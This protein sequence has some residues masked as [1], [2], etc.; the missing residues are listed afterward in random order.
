MRSNWLD[1]SEYFILNHWHRDERVDG[2]DDVFI[3]AE[4]D[5]HLEGKH[6]LDP[7]VS[8]AEENHVP[9]RETETECVPESMSVMFDESFAEKRHAESR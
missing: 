7:L 8:R 3:H 1:E 2:P 9:P 4:V 6:N 5:T